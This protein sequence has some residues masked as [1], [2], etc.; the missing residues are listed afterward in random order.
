MNLVESKDYKKL[1]G[2][3]VNLAL[4]IKKMRL[5]KKL[6]RDEA[7]KLFPFG[8]KNIEKLENGRGKVTDDLLKQFQ[9][10]YE[11]S[12]EV[13]HAIII[14]EIAVSEDANSIRLRNH[15]PR[16]KSKRFRQRIISRECAVLKELRL[17]RNLEQGQASTLCGFSK[18]KV[19]FIENGR[20]SLTKNRVEHMVI[21]YGFTMEYFNQLL[22]LDLLRHELIERSIEILKKLDDNKL[23]ILYP[24]LTSMAG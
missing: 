18:R 10:G 2:E 7:A 20:I 16:R 12:D 13:V 3:N 15:D 9:K 4:L 1:N 21:S 11:L 22:K 14:N 6:T 23:R 5:Y 17:L 19:G 8:Y 24:M